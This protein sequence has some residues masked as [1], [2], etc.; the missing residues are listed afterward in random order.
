MNWQMMVKNLLNQLEVAE[1]MKHSFNN[2]HAKGVK[3]LNLLRTEQLTVKVYIFPSDVQSEN[4][5]TKTIVNPHTHLYNFHTILLEGSVENV[6]FDYYPRA[7]QSG[8]VKVINHN[9][10][11]HNRF[12]YVTPFRAKKKNVGFTFE[13]TGHLI[14]RNI[15]IVDKYGKSYYMDADTIH[16]IRPVGETALLL[17]QYNDLLFKGDTD[18]FT[19]SNTAPSMEGLYEKFNESEIINLMNKVDHLCTRKIEV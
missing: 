14:E 7:Y 18:F 17:L 9:F 6:V 16:S 5:N 10:S 15:T 2:Y 19:Q 13:D 4:K 11:T 1:A 3:Y 12:R 8:E